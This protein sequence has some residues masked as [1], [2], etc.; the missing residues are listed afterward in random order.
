MDVEIS[1]EL[2]ASSSEMA[3]RSPADEAIFSDSSTT[4]FTIEPRR[5]LVFWNARP[6]T[7]NSSAISPGSA[8]RRSPS[9]RRSALRASRASGVSTARSVSTAKAAP[10]TALTTSRIA[11]M[12]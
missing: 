8:G 9:P 2:A 10:M 11:R 7:A 3:D 12:T 4:S 6:S 5:A 1:P